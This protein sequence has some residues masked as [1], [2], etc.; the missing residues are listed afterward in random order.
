M[1]G[2]PDRI[3][4]PARNCGIVPPM[5]PS[6]LSTVLHRRVRPWLVSV[7]TALLTWAAPALAAQTA[8]AGPARAAPPA[9]PTRCPADPAPASAE[10]VQ[11]QT[12]DRGILWTLTRDGHTSYLHASLHLGRPAWAAPGW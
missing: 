6:S 7:T 1:T 4:Q 11:A 10:Q 5:L 2:P 12:R 9:A 3:G 8:P